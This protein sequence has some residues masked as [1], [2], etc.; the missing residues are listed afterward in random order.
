M[1]SSTG[2]GRSS[3][4]VHE[5]AHEVCGWFGSNLLQMLLPPF[6]LVLPTP[7]NAP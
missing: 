2:R 5:L 6:S 4:F 7:S 1:V 3:L